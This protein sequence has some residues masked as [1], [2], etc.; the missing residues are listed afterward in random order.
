MSRAS[1][2]TLGVS[3]LFAVVSILGV[4]YMQ[5]LDLKTR[6]VGVVRDDA[7]RSAK[8]IEN[9]LEAKRQE[10]LRKM[11]ESDQTVSGKSFQESVGS[12]EKG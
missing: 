1:K 10:E 4:H 9:E 7:R 12:S 2:I 8:R 6:R 3:S 11:L 5:E